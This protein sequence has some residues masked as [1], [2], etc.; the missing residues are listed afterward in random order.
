MSFPARRIRQFPLLIAVF[1]IAPRHGIKKNPPRAVG[2]NGDA[3]EGAIEFY[4]ISLLHLQILV[5]RFSFE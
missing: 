2:E 4:W 3:R 1:N 5:C